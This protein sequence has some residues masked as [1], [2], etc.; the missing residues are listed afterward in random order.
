MEGRDSKS[1]LCQQFD[2]KVEH[3]ISACPILSKEQHTDMIR[4][5][6]VLLFITC[7][8]IGVKLENKHW[9][10]Q[11]PKSVETSREVM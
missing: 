4:V 10:D 6:A 1:S 11:V 2:E 9:Y 8:G 3:I 5:N 7:K